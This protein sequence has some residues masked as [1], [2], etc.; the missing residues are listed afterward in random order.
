MA[1]FLRYQQF[2]NFFYNINILWGKKCWKSGNR[3][4]NFNK[5]MKKVNCHHI[6][7][8]IFM[9][10]WEQATKKILQS[11]FK[12]KQNTSSVSESH[13]DNDFIMSLKND[14]LKIL[15][16]QISNI[17]SMVRWSIFLFERFHKWNSI[18]FLLKSDHS[19]FFYRF[20]NQFSISLSIPPHN[21]NVKNVGNEKPFS[22]GKLLSLFE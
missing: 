11:K 8:H 4:K 10:S 2:L 3:A 14:F 12:W 7:I 16:V 5:K 21:N 18:E 20:L 6:H 17:F 15:K 9:R 19:L 22:R 1:Y 13:V